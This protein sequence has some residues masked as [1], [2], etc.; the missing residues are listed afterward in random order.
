MNI[1]HTLFRINVSRRQLETQAKEQ[2]TLMMETRSL[3]TMK[4][5]RIRIGV[6]TWIL[7]LKWSSKTSRGSGVS[8]TSS[9]RCFNGSA[10][11]YWFVSVSDVI[12][13]S[14]RCSGALYDII[15]HHTHTFGHLSLFVTCAVGA[16]TIFLRAIPHQAVPKAVIW[17]PAVQSIHSQCL[18][19]TESCRQ[20]RKRIRRPKSAVLLK[21]QQQQQQKRIW[22]YRRSAAH[23]YPRIYPQTSG[24]RLVLLS[25]ELALRGPL[26]T[27]RDVIPFILPDSNERK[28]TKA[29]GGDFQIS[30]PNDELMAVLDKLNWSNVRDR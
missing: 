7:V 3:N 16:Q 30:N 1:M 12:G 18:W 28:T 9:R 13:D 17:L 22:N 8:S 4:L 24:S 5:Q 15:W 26:V 2:N 19:S 29:I 27:P 11:M 14:R 6:S 23:P 25:K 20:I 10:C 21:Q